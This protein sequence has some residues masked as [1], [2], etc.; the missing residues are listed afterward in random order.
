MVLFDKPK[1]KQEKENYY[2]YEQHHQSLEKK[3]N[4]QPVE[5]TL[6]ALHQCAALHHLLLQHFIRLGA[7]PRQW[8][9]HSGRIYRR[10]QKIG[11]TGYPRPTP[12]P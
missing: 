11:S 9:H 5:L 3:R 10:L 4:P 8:G 2:V 12:A 6:A 7:S 1:N